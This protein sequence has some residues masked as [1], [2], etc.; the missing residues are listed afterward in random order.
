MFWG[1]VLEHLEERE[2]RN[3]P[4]Q[5]GIA[6]TG[7]V[8]RALLNQIN[9]MKGIHVVAVANHHIQKGVDVLEQTDPPLPYG[10]CEHGRQ[11]DKVIEEGKVGIVKDPC[12]LASA[13]LEIVID[14]TGDPE[15]GSMLALL[16]IYHKKHFIA[17]PEMDALIGPIIAQLA[18][19]KGVIYSGTDGDEPGVTMGLF[20]YVSFL[21]HTIIAAGKF[22][23]FYDPLA[24]PSSV[25]K[26]AH[27]Y[28]QNPYMITSF[29]DG[30][31]MNLEMAILANATGLLPDTRGMH[32]C[33]SSLEEVTE[34]L[35]RREEGGILTRS[36][37]VEVVLDVE[38][39][40]GVF[41]VCKVEHPQTQRD[42]QYLKMGRGPFYL[43][44]HPYHLCG[45]EMGLTLV[46]AVLFQEAAIA[47]RGAPVVE[48]LSVAKRDLQKGEVLDS[49]GG[50]M[51]YGLIDNYI[52]VH[53]ERLLPLSLAPG[54]RVLRP[55]PK[56]YPIP[57]EAVRLRESSHL[58]R[59]WLLQRRFFSST[60]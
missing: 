24:T 45:M 2:R 15:L 4:I 30:S 40:S 53:Q 44:Y 31:K 36:G 57:L 21:G 48:V 42:L 8:G 55:I 17:S 20:R 12:L 1:N 18:R 6:G 49:I 51:Y 59:L 19:R 25:K 58:Y 39:S 60:L 27:E 13:Q 11:L 50:Y 9:S 38:P 37:V 46:R 29:A 43:F 47:P 26:W 23:G 3:R 14:C 35:R 7:F 32:C 52:S 28:Q 56:G 22:K 34:N 41:V 5:V 16:V 54:S 10:V 33:S